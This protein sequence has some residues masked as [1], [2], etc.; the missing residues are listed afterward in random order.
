MPTLSAWLSLLAAAIGTYGSDSRLKLMAIEDEQLIRLVEAATTARSLYIA[1][2]LAS[3]TLESVTQGA[4]PAEEPTSEKLEKLAE[5]AA[6]DASCEA[7]DEA[8]AGFQL[9][10]RW[11]PRRD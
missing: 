10:Q 9:S 3:V 4:T 5:L 7:A 2:C 6:A 8:L 1:L 11:A